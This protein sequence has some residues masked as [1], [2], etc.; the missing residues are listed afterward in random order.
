MKSLIQEWQNLFVH[1]F[2]GTGR[3]RERLFWVLQVLGWIGVSV[4]AIYPLLRFFG[5]GTTAVIIL[6]RIV[7]GVAVTC[8]L[9]L[10]Y[11]RI[12]WWTWPWWLLGALTALLC[13]F[14]GVTETAV[15]HGMARLLVEERVPSGE[16]QVFLFVTG[17]LLRAC[18]FI[19]W[20][21][22]YFGIKLWL[23]A[24]DIRVRDAE[25]EAAARTSELRQ[26]RAQVNPH[27]LFNALNSVLAEKDSPVAV[28][29]ITQGLAEY[30]RFSLRPSGDFQ[31]LG[32]ELNAIEH[33]LRIEKVRF[34][35]KLIYII[36][37]A[38]EVRSAR[39][40]VATVQPLLENAMKYG[41]QTTDGPLHVTISAMVD[42]SAEVVRITVENTGRWLEFDPARSHGIGLANLRRRLE[43]L[44]GVEASL[45]HREAD[46][47]VRVVVE[48][49]LTHEP[50]GS[51]D[52]NA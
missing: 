14:L 19:I 22:L 8:G 24:G 40:P 17:A 10:L 39:V 16:L 36:N 1:K 52:M 33:Y 20:S 41:R 45:S 42:H 29:R 15:T 35:E 43:L 3:E 18:L 46:G 27:F 9:R 4:I 5:P 47:R 2:E 26:L 32:D 30:L 44:Y 31:S 37:A 21:L 51:G 28:E 6:L 7:S 38:S 50:D 48:I 12:R 25:R 23:Q 49:P 34:E 13:I 11:R